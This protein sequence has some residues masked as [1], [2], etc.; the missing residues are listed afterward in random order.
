MN[1]GDGDG[2]TVC[3]IR[4]LQTGIEWQQIEPEALKIRGKGDD[5]K[6]LRMGPREGAEH[7]DAT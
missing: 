3:R 5:G 4:R 7:R 1:N 2:D 6:G